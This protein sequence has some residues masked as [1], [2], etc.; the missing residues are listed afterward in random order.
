MNKVLV[1][2]RLD[3]S[4]IRVYL[5]VRTV[6][7]FAAIAVVFGVTLGSTAS[8]LGI[9]AAFGLIFSA[10]PFAISD[11][12]NLDML[13]VTLGLSRRTVVRGRYVFGELII[14]AGLLI[15]YLAGT[16]VEVIRN[17]QIDPMGLVGLLLVFVLS[18]L[19]QACQF[20]I[21]FKAGYAKAQLWT[22]LPLAVV[23]IPVVALPPLVG[24]ERLAGMMTD[25]GAWMAGNLGLVIAA[26]ILIWGGVVLGSY[27]L[28]V[29]FYLRRDF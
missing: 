17:K 15:G 7:V 24:G 21:Q 29:R 9:F 26:L 10:Y 16:V 27:A 1:F 2:A 8:Q 3:F 5:T 6:L 23:G 12:I 28:S 18:S 22:W 11:K 4:T 20:P 14:L 19:I 13:Y 25:V